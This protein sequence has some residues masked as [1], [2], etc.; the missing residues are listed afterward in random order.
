MSSDEAVFDSNGL[1][2]AKPRVEPPFESGGQ[3]ALSEDW[4]VY[5]DGEKIVIPKGA[6]NDGASIPRFMWRIWGNPFDT[7]RYFAALVHDYLYRK[8]GTKADKKRADIAY[9]EIQKRMG[10]P[11]WKAN[12]EYVML[13]IFGGSSFKLISGAN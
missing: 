12:T 6:T 7:P 13:W 3:W 1:Q 11:A 8:G 10:V 5:Y 9:R 2:F 4:T